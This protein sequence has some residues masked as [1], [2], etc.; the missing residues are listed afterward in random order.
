MAAYK[1]GYGKGYGKRP[2][3]QWILIYLIIGGVVY[4]IIYYFFIRGSGGYKNPATPY[5][6]PPSSVTA[7]TAPKAVPTKAPAANPFGY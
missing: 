3:W 4:Y 7:T 2:L 6:A 1:K 5:V